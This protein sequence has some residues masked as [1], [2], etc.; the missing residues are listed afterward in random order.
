MGQANTEKNNGGYRRLAARAN[1]LAQDRVDIQFSVKEIAR[2]MAKPT[3]RAWA[4]LKRV[5]RYLKLRPRMVV[6]F[7]WQHGVSLLNSFTDSD[8]AGEKRYEKNA[9]VAEW[10]FWAT[11]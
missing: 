10:C 11:T 3:V 9:P 1:F 8:H 2:F 5:W 6:R 7:D 4:L